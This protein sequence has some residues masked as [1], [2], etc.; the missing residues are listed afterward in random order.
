MPPANFFTEPMHVRCSASCLTS[1]VAMRG[2]MS[3]HGGP[4]MCLDFCS[5]AWVFRVPHTGSAQCCS[6]GKRLSLAALENTAH[7][8]MLNHVLCVIA[9]R[10]YILDSS[11]NRLLSHQSDDGELGLQESLLTSQY[12]RY[13]NQFDIRS[14]RRSRAARCW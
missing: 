13:T 8:A 5:M 9:F 6:S 3:E 2:C 1:Q 7:Q 14:P 12:G 10:F 11:N 4:E